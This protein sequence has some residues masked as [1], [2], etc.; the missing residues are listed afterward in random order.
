VR[1]PWEEVAAGE[2]QWL[3]RP[4]GVKVFAVH[5]ARP[6]P[7]AVIVAGVHGDEYEGP[8]AALQLTKQ[9]RPEQ[10]AG[11]LAIVSVANPVAHAAGTRV[12]PDDGK[13]LAR[14]FPGRV[15]GS[16]T[17]ALAASLFDWMQHAQFLIDLHSGGVEYDFAPLAG[18]YGD[19]REGNTSFD[20]ATRFGLPYLWRLPQ[21]E[22]ALSCE[23]WR[24]GVTTLGCEYR[25]AGR[26]ST[27]GVKAYVAGVKSCLAL[28]RLLPDDL[29]PYKAGQ[30]VTGDWQLADSTGLFEAT[31]QL[32][33]VVSPGERLAD[34]ISLSGEAA[35]TF[36]AKEPS[37]V[38]AIRSRAPIRNGDWAV[39]TVRH[40]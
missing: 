13:N 6:G 16:A 29:P 10:L 17:E 19:V 28:W 3:S 35:Q 9:I 12:S 15:N 21:T 7:V 20:A 23:L 37:R 24:R 5:G 31:C 8:V 25:G 1:T 18:F 30:A 27:Q 39:L 22:G 4:F 2:S 34:I 26:L 40:A 14:T 32:E 38:L 36:A 33:E 11:S